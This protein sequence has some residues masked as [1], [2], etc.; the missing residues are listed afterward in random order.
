MVGTRT[1]LFPDD[2]NPGYH[3][4]NTKDDFTG[5]G[6]CVA[7]KVVGKNYGVAKD[8]DL[9]M[10]K[11]PVTLA[12]TVDYSEEAILATMNIIAH[13]INP[14]KKNIVNLSFGRKS[15]STGTLY[16]YRR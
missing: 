13:H 2:M 14:S 5:H 12:N 8:A 10:V 4:P 15:P 3:Y 16:P 9:V 11:W 1:W 6:S 7:S